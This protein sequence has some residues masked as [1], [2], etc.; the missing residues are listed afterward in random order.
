[1]TQNRLLR[2]LIVTAAVVFIALPAAAQKRIITLEEAVNIALVNNR[3]VKIAQKNVEKAEAAVR[4]AFGYALPTVDLNASYYR[5]LMKPKMAFPDFEALLGNATYGILFDEG[6]LPRDDSRFRPVGSTLQSFVQTNNFES[7]IQATQ[8]LFNSAVFRGIGT[9]QIYLD[10][11]KEELKR[12]ASTVILEVEKTFYGVLL[13][14]ELYDITDASFKNASE[15]LRNVRALHEQGLVAEFDFL[16]A[17][18]RVENIRPVL[19]QMENNLSMAGDGLKILL[20]IDQSIDIDVSGE[21]VYDDEQLPD[22]IESVQAA[23]DENLSIR[24]MQM[25]LKVDEAFIAL[26]RADYWPTIAAFANYSYAGSADDFKFQKYSSATVGVSFTINLFRGTQTYNR[27]QQAEANLNQSEEQYSQLEDFIIS[28]VKFRINEIRKV[29]ASLEAQERNVKLAERAYELATLRYK[30][31]T[32]SQLEIENSDIALR[33]AK[34]NRLQSV[35]DYILSKANL[36]QLLGRIDAS[37]L[38]QLDFND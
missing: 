4:E 14:K 37:H 8:I 24:S 10:L 27:V 32:G 7:T 25:K 9:S 12:T 19:L 22:E 31:G 33:Q 29:K 20:N 28:Q 30:E 1:M 2:I 18:V 38:N 11:S 23:L 3:E 35:Y 6:V 5:F 21:F 34:I 15:N 17:E 36:N 26:D 16:Q 13:S